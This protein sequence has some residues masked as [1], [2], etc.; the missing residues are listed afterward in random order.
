MGCTCGFLDAVLTPNTKTVS[1]V[2]TSRAAG[3]SSILMRLDG[4][5][6]DK[7][8]SKRLFLLPVAHFLWSPQACVHLGPHKTPLADLWKRSHIL[9]FFLCE[10]SFI[11]NTLIK[12]SGLKVFEGV[13]REVSLTP[14]SQPVSFVNFLEGIG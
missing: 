1:S 5:V 2:R 7:D 12:D 3:R 13:S 10:T 14:L 9:F 8:F 6:S 11:F 4:H